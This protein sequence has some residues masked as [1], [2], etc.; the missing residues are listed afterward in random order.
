MKN[1][2]SYNWWLILNIVVII[3]LPTLVILR[4]D[5]KHPFWE[6]KRFIQKIFYLPLL[7]IA[8][9]LARLIYITFYY[10][11]IFPVSNDLNIG[12]STLSAIPVLVDAGFW[13]TANRLGVLKNEPPLYR[14]SMLLVKEI[15]FGIPITIGVFYLVKVILL[16]VN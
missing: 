4:Q 1:L 9:I 7:I 11:M 6:H 5:R 10:M 14:T 2:E 16:T 13:F 12:I 3:I 15:F 8:Y